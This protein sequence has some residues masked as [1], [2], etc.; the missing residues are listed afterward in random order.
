M[1][2]VKHFDRKHD[3]PYLAGYSL[4]GKTIYIVRRPH[5]SAGTDQERGADLTFEGANALRDRRGR[6]IQ[7]TRGFRDR[8]MVNDGDETVQE[9]RIHNDKKTISRRYICPHFIS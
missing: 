9:L 6:E 4:D 5:R 8:S 3:I 7:S 1:R 2:R